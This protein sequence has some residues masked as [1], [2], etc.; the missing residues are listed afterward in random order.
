MTPA[1]VVIVLEADPAL[2][3]LLVDVLTDEGFAV[4]G[5][6]NQQELMETVGRIMPLLLILDA[7][8]PELSLGHLRQMCARQKLSLPPVVALATDHEHGKQMI[9]DGAAIYLPKPFDLDMFVSVVQR[10]TA[11]AVGQRIAISSTPII[12]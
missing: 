7:H 4:Y 9:Q 11:R 3:G 12:A 2:S 6:F 10:F 1:S 5:V 8:V